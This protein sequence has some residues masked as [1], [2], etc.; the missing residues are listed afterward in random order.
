MANPQHNRKK[1][2]ILRDLEIYCPRAYNK[3]RIRV[4]FIRGRIFIRGARAHCTTR[5]SRQLGVLGRGEEPARGATR[6]TRRAYR[7]GATARRSFIWTRNFFFPSV[8]FIV[9]YYFEMGGL[10]ILILIL[11]VFLYLRVREF[12]RKR[13]Y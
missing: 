2:F 9:I 5:A 10:E 11:P 4:D 3:R 12:F 13:N 7:H 8:Y 1:A 6:T